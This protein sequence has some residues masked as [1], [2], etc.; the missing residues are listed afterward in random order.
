[1]RETL[2]QLCFRSSL[3]KIV[4]PNKNRKKNYSSSPQC[5][6]LYFFLSHQREVNFFK[7]KQNFL[8][9]CFKLHVR[10]DTAVNKISDKIRRFVG[11]DSKNRVEEKEISW[12]K[13]ESSLGLLLE[14]SRT[15]YVELSAPPFPYAGLRQSL[16]QHPMVSATSRGS[17]SEFSRSYTSQCQPYREKQS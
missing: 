13:W 5:F 10:L 16:Q 14:S 3:W 1:M 15:A 8:R 9:K 4:F 2:L 7:Y 17:Q 6:I 12:K 11:K